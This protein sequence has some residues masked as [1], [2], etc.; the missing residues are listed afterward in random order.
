MK[1]LSDRDLV[2]REYATVDRLVMRRLDRTAWLGG[3][4]EP[5]MLALAAI[6]LTTEL[7]SCN[8]RSAGCR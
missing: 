4:H 5:W 7:G 3:E 8:G 1:K 6:A 2:A